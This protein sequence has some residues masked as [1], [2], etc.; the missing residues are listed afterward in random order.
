MKNLFAGSAGVA[1][2]AIYLGFSV[3]SGAKSEPPMDLD[4]AIDLIASARYAEAMCGMVKPDVEALTHYFKDRGRDLNADDRNPAHAYLIER[5]MVREHLANPRF[6]CTQLWNSYGQ[7]GATIP[8]L[9]K[10]VAPRS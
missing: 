3:L 10:M 9:L 4:N 7:S 2:L 1:V 5:T 6:R 8:G